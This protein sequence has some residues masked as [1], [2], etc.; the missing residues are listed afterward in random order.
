MKKLFLL[1]LLGCISLY[2]ARVIPISN[3]ENEDEGPQPLDVQDDIAP[4]F[5]V[6]DERHQDNLEAPQPG[7]LY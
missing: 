5:N 2:E 3:Q 4:D 7:L 1:L 6:N